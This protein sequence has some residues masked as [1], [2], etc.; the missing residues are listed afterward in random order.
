MKVLFYDDA[1][2]VAFEAPSAVMLEVFDYARL[3]SARLHEDK[4]ATIEMFERLSGSSEPLEGEYHTFQHAYLCFLQGVQDAPE[5]KVWDMRQSLER[6]PALMYSLIR[7][8]SANSEFLFVTVD[9]EDE[10]DKDLELHKLM[11]APAGRA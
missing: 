5:N 6:D 3:P 11:I 7:T 1:T 8:S 10:F 9:N 4:E 2:T